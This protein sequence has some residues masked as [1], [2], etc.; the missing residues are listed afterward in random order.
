MSHSPSIEI[1]ASGYGRIVGRIDVENAPEALSRGTDLFAVG[2]PL[3]ADISEL[4]SADSI[5]LAVLLALAARARKS[6]GALSFT[7]ASERLKAI[8]HLGDAEPLLGFGG[9]QVGVV[10]A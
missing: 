10:D 8:A 2:K 9:D 1:M 6:G 5:T 4:Q 3:I 7:R